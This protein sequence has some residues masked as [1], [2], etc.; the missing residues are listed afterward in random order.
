[1]Y[2]LVLMAALTTGEQTPELF[3]RNGCHGC[4]GGY[5]CHG[6]YGGGWGCHGCYGC[7]GACYGYGYG[8]WGGCYGG[9]GCIGGC[10]GGCGGY[11]GGW[12]GC[13]GGGYGCWGASY[14]CYAGCG[15][16]AGMGY[17]PVSGGHPIAS[18]TPTAPPTAAR[19]ESTRARLIIELPADAKLFVDG[20]EIKNVSTRKTFSTPAL[21]AGSEYYY[22]V[23]AEVMRDGE[24]V[25]ETR[26][27]IVTAGKEVREDFRSMGAAATSTARSR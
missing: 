5:G 24:P 19:E 27:V 2:S 18:S 6:C 10:Y 25:K 26:R 9:G 1:M 20:Q 13:Y 22:E 3:H 7:Y 8:G 15:G 23:R 12:G 4:Y 14:G 17:A 21:Q 11:G 16:Y